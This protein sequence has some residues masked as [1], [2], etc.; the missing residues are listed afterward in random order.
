M[1]VV[2]CC[3]IPAKTLRGKLPVSS[4]VRHTQIIPPNCV[5]RA[6]QAL[7]RHPPQLLVGPRMARFL[8]FCP[9]WRLGGKQTLCRI[10]TE[11][12]HPSSGH[13]SPTACLLPGGPG[14]QTNRTHV[15]H[16]SHGGR[17]PLSSHCPLSNL[18][19]T[20]ERDPN[21]P[22]PGDCPFG[23]DNGGQKET[24]TE[25]AATTTVKDCSTGTTPTPTLQLTLGVGVSHSL[26]DA[27]AGMVH[28][29]RLTTPPAPS[30]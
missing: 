7:C 23:G 4:R 24:A 15:H 21:W 2:D 11:C 8:Y 25:S 18:D 1:N 14:E 30:R 13:W 3:W 6:F 17:G 12:P 9:I 26:T 28:T 5:E 10:T 27:Y 20:L 16:P 29:F 19:Q 22:P